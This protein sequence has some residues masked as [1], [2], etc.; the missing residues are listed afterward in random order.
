MNIDVPDNATNLFQHRFRW[1]GRVKKKRDSRVRKLVQRSINHWY[2]GFAQCQSFGVPGDSNYFDG[3]LVDHKLE[4]TPQCIFTWPKL[5]GHRFI[6]DCDRSGVLLGILFGKITAT[7]KLDSHRVEITG[8]NRAIV[9]KPPVMLIIR[10]TAVDKDGARFSAKSQRY[11][12]V[13][14]D[15]GNAL[16]LFQMINN[17]AHQVHSANGVVAGTQWINV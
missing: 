12:F 17:R 1:A 13:Y 15:C 11:P 9:G 14:P 3:H 7:Q 6:D 2:G 5:F 8:S 10:V 4:S 16:I